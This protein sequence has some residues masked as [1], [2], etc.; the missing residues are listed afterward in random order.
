MTMLVTLRFW[1][2]EALALGAANTTALDYAVVLVV[3]LSWQ[4]KHAGPSSKLS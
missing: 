1:L 3:D 4:S 2:A